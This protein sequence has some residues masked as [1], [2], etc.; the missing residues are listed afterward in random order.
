[1]AAFQG[2]K[3]QVLTNGTSE[4]IPQ[5]CHKPKQHNNKNK[6]EASGS[7]QRPTNQDLNKL[8]AQDLSETITKNSFSA[9]KWFS[10]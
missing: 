1:M 10:G 2:Q 7:P 8:L 5:N 3:A 4:Q 9:T 6:K